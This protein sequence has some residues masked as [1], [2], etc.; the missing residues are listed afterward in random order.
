M[1][2][3]V[4][5]NK[6]VVWFPLVWLLEVPSPL[7][8]CAHLFSLLF[9]PHFFERRLKLSDKIVFSI[10]VPVP[11]CAL[12]HTQ[13]K[14]TH[15]HTWAQIFFFFLFTKIHT[16]THWP[17]EKCHA[18]W[19]IRRCQRGAMEWWNINRRMLRGTRLKR[20]INVCV[21]VRALTPDSLFLSKDVRDQRQDKWPQSLVRSSAQILACRTGV[22]LWIQSEGGRARDLNHSQFVRCNQYYSMRPVH[23]DAG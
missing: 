4:H 18:K 19:L 2:P 21:C 14:H 7:C 13:Q 15:T 10:G 3:A 17:A 20:G 16:Y 6:A 8:P 1:D 22:I 9:G 12:Q 11:D 23:T 5:L